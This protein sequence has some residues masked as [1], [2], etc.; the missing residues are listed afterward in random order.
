MLLVDGAYYEAIQ[1]GVL[2]KFGTGYVVDV[3]RLVRRLEEIYEAQF[4]RRH[5]VQGTENGTLSSFHKMLTSP[6]NKGPGFTVD[7]HKMRE[8]SV[9]RGGVV[10]PAE[11]M[12]DKAS[13]MVEQ[14][15]DVAISM[16]ILR[17]TMKGSFDSLVVITGDAGLE[18]AFRV[19]SEENRERELL[20]EKVQELYV[21]GGQKMSHELFSYA[22]GVRGQPLV[23]LEAIMKECVVKK[24]ELEKSLLG[25][26]AISGPISSYLSTMSNNTTSTPPILPRSVSNSS[27]SGLSSW[28]SDVSLSGK[29]LR[30]CASDTG[31]DEGT[32]SRGINVRW[33]SYGASCKFLACPDENMAHFKKYGHMCPDDQNC[34]FMLDYAT[35]RRSE[36]GKVHFGLWRHSCPKGANCNFVEHP[37]L[38]KKHMEK[39]THDC[40]DE[41]PPTPTAS[42]GP[43]K[44]SCS[45]ATTTSG[46]S[47]S[48]SSSRLAHLWAPPTE[49]SVDTEEDCGM[50][51][52]LLKDVANLL[53][54]ET[55]GHDHHH[56][57]H[58]PHHQLQQQPPQPESSLFRSP[59]MM[60]GGG[61][62]GAAPMRQ[63]G[64]APVMLGSKDHQL[65]FTQAA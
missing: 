60:G 61:G 4:I 64:G 3:R 5:Y 28:P 17:T 57:H 2:D 25:G 7:I 50:P 24:E 30:S 33:C 35:H 11:Y 42:L 37:E 23:F 59:F 47:P 45:A 62:G 32:S 6:E 31:S 49:P 51:L 20:K 52:V 27:R 9:R 58:H 14:G 41:C 21:L 15:V 48:V 19:A 1:W 13:I 43:L 55:A 10:A 36:K 29:G 56:H 12:R 16:E 26:D 46:P 34:P 38:H 22:R 40:Y 53:L 44:A 65:V 18:P 39:F 8:Q 54:E 63:F